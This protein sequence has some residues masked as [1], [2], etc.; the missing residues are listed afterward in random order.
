M[1]I[2]S[3]NVNSVRAR[4]VRVT[5]WLKERQPDVVC[6]QELKVDDGEF[7]GLE[8]RAA[9]YRTVQF[10]QKTYNGVAI[11]AKEELGDVACGIDDGVEDPQARLIAATVRGVRVVCVYVPNGQAVG[12][13]KYDYKLKWLGRL[14]AYLERRY[15]PSEPVIVCGDFN[16]APEPRDVYAP[17]E[18]EGLTL[19][20]VDARAAMERVRAW[21]LHDTFRLLHQEAGAY[22]WWDYRHLGFEN[23]YGLRIDHIFATEPLA[24]R[25]T[26]AWI[27]REARK[28]KDAS[29]HAP[30]IAEFTD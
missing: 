6:L 24:R 8:L 10:C 22:S 11:L 20:H 18:W 30:V 4:M 28:G 23:D 26:A 13:D 1:R 29:D 12:S 16:V 15:Q 2:A 19:F 14:R 5:E 7:P 17:R 27:D 9:G 3:W 25:C 21:G